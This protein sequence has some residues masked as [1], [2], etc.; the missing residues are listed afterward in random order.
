M[1]NQEAH[2]LTLHNSGPLDIHINPNGTVHINDHHNPSIT[3]T[4]TDAMLLA[5]TILGA[6]NHE[7]ALSTHNNPKPVSS[8]PTP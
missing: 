7:Q 5:A 4:R 6:T 3:L 8:Q 2:H 1:P